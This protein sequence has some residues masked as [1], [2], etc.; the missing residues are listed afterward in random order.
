MK[1]IGICDFGTLRSVDVSTCFRIINQTPSVCEIGP[2]VC[3]DLGISLF[4]RITWND[5]N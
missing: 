5:N 4:G 3:W 2:T 1:A